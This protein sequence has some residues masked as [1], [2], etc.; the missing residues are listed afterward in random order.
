MVEYQ[1]QQILMEIIT[2]II[3]VTDKMAKRSL[4]DHS[5]KKMMNTI[6]KWRKM[7]MMQIWHQTETYSERLM[8]MNTEVV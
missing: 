5:D 8:L 1:E 4:I 6:K 3:E 7:K 2:V